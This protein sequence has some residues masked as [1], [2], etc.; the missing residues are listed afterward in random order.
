VHS[1]D[2]RGTGQVGLARDCALD[3]AVGIEQR[4]AHRVGIDPATSS[5]PCSESTSR[6]LASCAIAPPPTPSATTKRPLD[7]VEIGMGI[8]VFGSAGCRATTRRP[9][10]SG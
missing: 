3:R 1:T 4:G 9:P 8:F 10:R 5:A 6:R 2:R 7:A